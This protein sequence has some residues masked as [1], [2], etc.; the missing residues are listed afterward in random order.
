MCLGWDQILTLSETNFSCF[1]L[2]VVCSH[3]YLW[4]VPT[5]ICGLSPLIFVVYTH[6]YLYHVPTYICLSTLIFV[7]WPHWYLSVPT[8]QL[9]CPRSCCWSLCRGSLGT[10][11]GGGDVKW[12]GELLPHGGYGIKDVLSSRRELSP[13]RWPRKNLCWWGREND[14]WCAALVT[15]GAPVLP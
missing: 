9:I 2:C 15:H 6:W 12:G 14:G 4:Y 7:V 13:L 8:N 3:W 5:D 11:T 10:L 1:L